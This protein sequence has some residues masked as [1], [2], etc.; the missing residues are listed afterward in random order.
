MTASTLFGLAIVVTG[1]YNLIY[2]GRIVLRSWRARRW[3]SVDGQLLS[4]DL[5]RRKGLQEGLLAQAAWELRVEYR[6]SVGTDTHTG[7]VISPDGGPAFFTEQLGRL[8][9]ARQWRPGT[10]VKVQVN[11]RHP[12][13]A[14]LAPR[15]SAATL[16][17]LMG[18]IGLLAGGAAMLLS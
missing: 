12:E 18:G 13:D 9:I 7:V 8:S 14:M 5:R 15:V 10:T 3:S 16:L 11:P 2:A 1:C 17:M 6:Y 4:A